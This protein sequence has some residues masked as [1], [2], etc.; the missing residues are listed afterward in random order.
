ME[1]YDYNM[2]FQK[3]K[4]QLLKII[5]KRQELLAAFEEHKDHHCIM[6]YLRLNNMKY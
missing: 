6:E 4:H 1:G 2:V 3:E 5:Y